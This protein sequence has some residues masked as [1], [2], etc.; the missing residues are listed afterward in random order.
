MPVLSRAGRDSLAAD[1]RNQKRLQSA[2]ALV[3][4]GS[5]GLACAL[6]DMILS[7]QPSARLR[8]QVERLKA[9][10]CAGAGRH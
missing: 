2:D 7:D 6:Y 1:A 9:K 4:N 10:Y 3:S 8:R 5:A